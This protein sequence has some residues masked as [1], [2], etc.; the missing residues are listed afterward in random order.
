MNLIETNAKIQ[1]LESA[2]DLLRYKIDGWCAWPIFRFSLA[3]IASNL[4]IDKSEIRLNY[5]ERIKLSFW[6]GY[7]FFLAKHSKVLLCVASSNRVELEKGRYKDIIFDD[8]LQYFPSYTKIEH[9][10][11]KNYLDHSNSALYPSQLTTNGISLISGIFSRLNKPKSITLIA[12]NFQTIIKDVLQIPNIERKYI[13]QLLL[14]YYWRKILYHA[15]FIKIKPKILLL[16]TAY[17]NHAIVAAAKELNIRVIEFQHGIIDR[18]HPGYSWTPYAINY[19]KYMPIPDR[20]FVYGEYWREELVVNGFWNNELRVV[21]SL[22][23]DQFRSLKS[24]DQPSKSSLVTTS[25]KI[26]VTTQAL[27]VEHLISFILD[28][29][30]VASEPIEIDIKLHP[31]ESN[32]L[33][34]E[35]AFKGYP[36]IHIISGHESPSTFELLSKADYHVSIHS[37]CHFEAL[38]LGIPTI[39]LPFTNHERILPLLNKAPGYTFLANTPIEMNRIIAQDSPVPDEITSYFFSPGALQNMLDELHREE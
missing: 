33:P 28:F 15:L 10:N 12:D 11:N 23:M 3:A 19:K 18:F 25:K 21:G 8:L 5:G 16:Q 13:R 6:D 2:Y 9:I 4:A 24:R 38:G 34:Y 35:I 14:G 7:S 27:D 29:L 30:K 1:E 20:I 32:R 26:V 31:R 36:N 17:T 37:T 39:I 22:H